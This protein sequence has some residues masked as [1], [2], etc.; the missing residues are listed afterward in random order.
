MAM[1]MFW[2]LR[3][4]RNVAPPASGTAMTKKRII[5]SRKAQAQSLLATMTKRFPA[6]RVSPP[7]ASAATPIA[8]RQ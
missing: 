6:V 4:V 7:V 2:L 5:S 1:R 3:T 8:S